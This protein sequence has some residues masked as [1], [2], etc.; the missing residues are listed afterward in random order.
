VKGFSHLVSGFA[1][2]MIDINYLL[3]NTAAAGAAWSDGV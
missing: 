2:L 1:N 3:A